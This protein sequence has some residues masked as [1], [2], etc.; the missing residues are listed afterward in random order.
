M[1]VN[2]Q[3]NL[4]KNIKKKTGQESTNTRNDR[5]KKWNNYCAGGWSS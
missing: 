4:L 2:M 3:C 5:T 1:F